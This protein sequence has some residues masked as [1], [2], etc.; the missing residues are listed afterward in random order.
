MHA[1]PNLEA[2][3]LRE[4]DDVPDRAAPE[5]PQAAVLQLQRSAGNQATLA[6]L[7]P[8]TR[9]LSRDPDA[10]TADAGTAPASSSAQTSATSGSPD[11]AAA[12]DA[13]DIGAIK[14]IDDFR[15][16]SD[17]QRLS[18]I[19]I[20]LDQ[21]WVGPYDEAA[22]ERIWESFG[23]RLPETMATQARL[24]ADC[25][26]RG[27]ELPRWTRYDNLYL[28]CEIQPGVI[29]MRQ[30][31]RV[32]P[33]VDALSESDYLQF[34]QLMHFAGSPMQLAFICKALAAERSV[35]DIATFA[36]TI[37]SQPDTWLISNLAITPDQTPVGSSAQTGAMQQWQMSCGPTTVQVLQAETDPIFALSITSG[38]AINDQTQS[39]QA[40]T[41]GQ[42]TILQGQGST[43]TP[44]GTAG[45]GAWVESD[46]NALSAS[47]GVTYTYTS[48]TA[49]FPTN[50]AD[51][52]VDRAVTRII[53]FLD[54]DIPVPIVI[55]QGSATTAVSTAHYVMCLRASGD[56]IL[57]HDP[58][59][60]TTAWVGRAQF[61]SN[62][63]APPLSWP[64]L[65]GYDRPST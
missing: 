31:Q 8:S 23:E 5:P 33:R 58:G 1:R 9:T 13:R 52:D 20:L 12:I 32:P 30:V 55:G 64:S 2:R 61:L 41:T 62:G 51:S 63:L 4:N 46:M 3:R 35:G 53:A 28:T 18:M 26:D 22:L 21:W 50:A 10:G 19:E 42:A 16:A 37:R 43:P 47:T 54:R 25:V 40:L 11:F 14:R 36:N 6:L 49:T 38:G 17:A 29:S 57:I 7:N 34:R 60:G 39:N 65:A 45:Q 59:N 15:G 56:Q 48:V 27:A 24:W 44:V